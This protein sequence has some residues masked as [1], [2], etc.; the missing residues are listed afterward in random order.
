MFD[1]GGISS[2]L[3]T[4]QDVHSVEPL[5][6][7]GLKLWQLLQRSKVRQCLCTCCL[8]GLRHILD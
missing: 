2:R 3:L 4:V 8:L 6:V 7:Q 1:F 5:T